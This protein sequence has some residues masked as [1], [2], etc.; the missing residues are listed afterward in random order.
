MKFTKSGCL[1]L[2][3]AIS[4]FVLLGIAGLYFYHNDEK[5]LGIPGPEANQLALKMQKA[6][7]LQAWKE[8]KYI[9][10]DFAGQHQHLWDKER[11]LAKVTWGD[12]MV[13]LNPSTVTGAAYAKGEKLGNK[14]ESDKLVKEAWEYFINDSFWLNAPSLALQPGTSRELV[15]GDDGD[16]QLL[17]SYTTGG[18]TPVDSYLW[19]LDENGLPISYKMWVSIIPV[20]GVEFTW[21]NWQ[22]LDNGAMISRTHVGP[23]FTLELTDIKT[24]NSGEDFGLR[25]DPFAEIAVIR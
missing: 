20:G 13:L 22:P 11:H 10:W 5:P 8:I 19:K 24:G 4:A 3:V 6:I 25:A 1:I 17:V 2:I 18:A 23:G 21:E 12:N 14:D 15:K 9:S 7:N 16:K